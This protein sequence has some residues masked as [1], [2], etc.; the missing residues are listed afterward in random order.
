[1]NRWAG[2]FLVGQIHK[3][4]KNIHTTTLVETTMDFRDHLRSLGKLTTKPSRQLKNRAKVRL[5]CLWMLF[6]FIYLLR[7]LGATPIS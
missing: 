4:R 3:L 7:T 6:H 2:V 1:M 5:G